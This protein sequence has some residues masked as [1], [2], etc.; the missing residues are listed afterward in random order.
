M[1]RTDPVP[2]GYA[3]T[4]EVF[5]ESEW[6]AEHLH[7]PNVRT[8]EVDVSRAAYN[9][10]HIPGAVLWNAYSD[11]H[12]ADYRPVGRDEFQEL[13]RTSGVT[14]DDTVVVYG[15][16]PYL[17][18]WL[19]RAYGHRRALVLNGT[20]QTWRDARLPWTTDPS[21]PTRTAYTLPATQASML[22][23]LDAVQA[24]CG[25]DSM[26][27]L[28]MRSEAEFA[29]ERFWPSGA[30]EGAGRAGHIPGA[31]HLPIDL[32][33]TPDGALKDAAALRRV[34]E[35]HGVAP[36]RSVVTYCTIGARASEAA[37]VLRY[38]LGYPSVH[39]YDGSWAEWGTRQDTPVE[40]S[41]AW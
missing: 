17:G 30:T 5:V 9:Q 36:E 21:V 2:S 22:M 20:R 38:T 40:S 28:D 24:A 18:Y 23:P 27:I 12:R 1:M 34:F 10:G 35:E 6:L 15:Y 37:S 33:H 3:Y 8:V 14:P 13:L 39:V 31:V 4:S 7:D 41:V 19:L 26:L 16:A 25:S 11:L 29:G 32:L